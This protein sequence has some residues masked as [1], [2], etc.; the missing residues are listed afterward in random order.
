MKKVSQKTFINYI[1]SDYCS[2]IQDLDSQRGPRFLKLKEGEKQFDKM[3]RSLYNI[4]DD[5]TIKSI[6]NDRNSLLMQLW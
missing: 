4:Q 6:I 3:N 2:G 5:L 1:M